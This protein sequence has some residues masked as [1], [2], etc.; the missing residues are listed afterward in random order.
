MCSC[1]PCRSGS[2]HIDKKKLLEIARRNAMNMIQAGILPGTIPAA[3]APAAAT[4]TNKSE[5]TAKTVD[6]L[7]G[8]CF[9][10]ISLSWLQYLV[11]FE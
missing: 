3:A 9:P 6:E 5:K 4:V 1:A 2:D 10:V 8:N 11:L 7:T